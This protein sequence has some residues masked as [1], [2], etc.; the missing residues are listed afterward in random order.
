MATGRGQ[1]YVHRLS[2]HD[3]L[4]LSEDDPLVIVDTLKNDLKGFQESLNSCHKVRPTSKGIYVAAVIRILN[5]VC[6]VTSHESANIIIAEFLSERCSQFHALLKEHVLK[7]GYTSSE[8][9]ISAICKLFK[10]V[11]ARQPTSAWHVLPIDDLVSASVGLHNKRSIEELKAQRD[12]IR[13]DIKQQKLLEQKYKIQRQEVIQQEHFRNWDN[14]QYRTVSILPTIP[15][16]LVHKGPFLRSNLINS[17]YDSWEH[18]YDVQFRLLREDFLA[19]LRRGIHSYV[20][21]AR[22][23]QLHDI[24]IYQDVSLVRPEFTRQGACFRIRLNTQKMRMG[25]EQS[26][27][28]I[29]G[30]LLCFSNYDFKHSIYFATVVEREVEDM[31]KNGEIIVKFES[32]VEMLA[33]CQST[34]FVVA[35]SRAY[36]E[37][38]SHILRSL[39]LAE[40]DTMPFM[41]YLIKNDCSKINPPA[42]L[43]D[44]TVPKFNLMWLFPQSSH[45]L[46]LAR[47]PVDLLRSSRWP[48]QS[49]VQ[50][51]E[52][53]LEA[54][55][56]ALTQEISVIQG[57]PGTGK[58]YIGYKIVQTLLQN[59]DVWDP[60]KSSPI[61]VMC[62]TN[63]ALDQFLEG[64]LDSNILDTDDIRQPHI[65]RVGGRSES[66][67]IQKLNI[68]KVRGWI[69]GDLLKYR[70]HLI[71]QIESSVKRMPWRTLCMSMH[72]TVDEYIVGPNGIPRLEK[73][74]SPTHFYQ[75]STLACNNEEQGYI[76]ELWLG[77]W[78]D[79]TK[80]NT[81]IGLRE[82][83]IPPKQL[84]L[85]EPETIAIAGEGVTESQSRMI[86]DDAYAV[87]KTIDD[88]DDPPQAP[89]IKLH[90]RKRKN[91]GEIKR[92]IQLIKSNH[93]MTEE[94]VILIKDVRSLSLNK[95]YRLFLYWIKQYQQQLKQLNENRFTQYNH[96]C[97]QLKE[98]QQQI[99]RY[100]LEKAEVIG[101]TTTG[102]AK[103]QHIIHLVKPK[104]V[105]VEE[106]AEVMESHIVSA[107]S[108]STEHLILIGDH[109]QLRPKPNEYDLAMKHNLH[110]SLF[111]RLIKSSL[112][113]A[114][115]FQQHRMRPEIARLVHPH[116]YDKLENHDTVKH[117]RNVTGFKKNMYFFHHE[118]EEEEDD[119]SH[120]NAFEAEF[121]AALC[122]HILNQG[123]K[124][125][126][127]TILTPYTGQL[128]KLKNCMPKSQY[129]GV[130]VT[131]VDNFQ[132]E[133]NEIII[134]S[135]VRSNKLGN[136][137]FLKEDNRVCVSLSRAKIGLYCFGN[138]KLLRQSSTVWESIL[139]DVEKVG[140]L[141]SSFELFCHNHPSHEYL[142]NNPKEIPILFPSGGCF[143]M[144]AHRLDCGHACKLHCHPNHSEYKCMENCARKCSEGHSCTRKCYEDC[145]PCKI[146]ITRELPCNHTKYM[147]C[148]ENPK[149]VECFQL[150]NKLCLRGLHKCKRICSKMCGECQEEIPTKLPNCGHT[151]MVRCSIAASRHLCIEN[152][153]KQ[154]HVCG[155]FTI[156]PC[157]Q[158]PHHYRC[159]LPCLKTL[160]CGHTC[161]KRCGENCK[162][163]EEIEVQ[164][165]C[166]HQYTKHCGE[167]YVV[168]CTEIVE[169]R[170]PRNHV[171]QRKC[172]ESSKACDNV[173][174]RLLDCGHT[175]TK[176][177]SEDCGPCSVT[178]TKRCPY[179]HSYAFKCP[180]TSNSGASQCSEKCTTK[181]K[182][183][184]VCTGK[185]GEC[186]S[187]RIHNPCPYKLDLH[188]ICGHTKTT[189]CIGLQFPCIR[190][191]SLVACSH[192]EQCGH[193]CWKECRERCRQPCIVKCRHKQCL[194][195]CDVPCRLTACNEKCDKLLVCGHACPGLCG[196]K[197]PT[198]CIICNRETLL[199]I[200]SK[201]KCGSSLE[202][203]RYIQLECAHI[204]PVEYMDNYIVANSV[205][206][207]LQCPI[208][209]CNK[210]LTSTKRYWKAVK[211]RILEIKEIK[212][213]STISDGTVR[214]RFGIL[215]KAAHDSNVS[216]DRISFKPYAKSRLLIGL[217]ETTETA[218]WL[219]IIEFGNNVSDMI[220]LSSNLKFNELRKLILTYIVHL[221]GALSHQL[222]SDITSELYRIVIS[223]L[224]CIL[225]SKMLSQNITNIRV[226]KKI[227][228]VQEVLD[229][230]D[231]DHSIRITGDLYQCLYTDLQNI[232]KVVCPSRLHRVNRNISHA[233]ALPKAT[234][235]EWHKCAHGH[236]YFVPATY[237]GK[238]VHCDVCHPCVQAKL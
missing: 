141:G 149:E 209:T 220:L 175:C 97:K 218:C 123:Y 106:A 216:L 229:K 48:H 198:Y 62:L 163:E 223:H 49:L 5:K 150:C 103:Y 88:E 140:C 29:F 161:Q 83:F 179:Q 159:F 71:T 189:P 132:G 121:A 107:L 185:C 158:T 235:G 129:E 86:D 188:A 46:K 154:L 210:P 177:C 194:K 37:A 118:Y 18:Y 222:V 75:L 225:Q 115:L 40:T 190:K 16:V 215:F 181:L 206:T 78:E 9:E 204:F 12:R 173:C 207:P 199:A 34:R 73:V 214:G 68:N 139:A 51:D 45:D 42:Y 208:A 172:S 1:F 15:E 144:C 104:I 64:L 110:I 53:Q 143:R 217:P 182:C 54:V 69:P 196:E 153:S 200:T 87:I 95:R 176:K 76:L 112:P 128:F 201:Y 152:V 237:T 27:K 10:S 230:M 116:I 2:I 193:R 11:L 127:I 226:L 30:S 22:G 19:P 100:A 169:A 203:N 165:T 142:I 44:S 41:N 134:L 156:M 57:P 238:N 38:S 234:K 32:N 43:S 160:L 14:S 126:E 191:C 61:L 130:R 7:V 13:A 92:I 98:T 109:K 55:K 114:T 102:A 108:A 213:L 52:S 72:C 146:L 133:E 82:A 36:Y 59:R 171:Y 135:L 56:M 91:N 101:M 155:H 124:P 105:I 180:G 187:R 205:I 58:T 164:L 227:G 94:D 228:E 50:L 157:H 183:G 74:M 148:Y 3:L 39:Q 168:K 202:A 70:R 184:H 192:H 113:H 138:F 122:K 77:M 65:V 232:V 221:K 119:T 186:Y 131:C 231:S 170:C 211:E 63:H 219:D 236:I 60:H 80:L 174:G 35:E 47:N 96:L 167:K 120:S 178:V 99:D 23:R 117:Y 24:I 33:H 233:I 26:K 90:K 93:P 21:G 28:L 125:S 79:K 111:E 212:K 25:W 4:K 145:P 197:C 66:E 136:V 67:R 166:G 17:C 137:G 8:I 81:I 89:Q 20:S 224:S 6:Q 147:Q 31:Q 151:Q 195:Q 162:C 85:Q 84:H